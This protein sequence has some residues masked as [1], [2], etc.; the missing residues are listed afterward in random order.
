M[1]KKSKKVRAKQFAYEKRLMYENAS[2][3]NHLISVGFTKEQAIKRLKN[4]PRGSSVD[5]LENRVK[6]ALN[7]FNVTGVSL[8]GIVKSKDVLDYI[9]SLEKQD[10]ILPYRK[11]Q[12]TLTLKHPKMWIRG[13]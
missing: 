1:T 3:F 13:N 2:E 12:D 6:S 10:V 7:S 11:G 5:R 4:K 8:Q 9:K